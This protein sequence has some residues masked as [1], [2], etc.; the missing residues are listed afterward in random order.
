[1]T[2]DLLALDAVTLRDRLASGE[3]TALE[4]TDACLAR[5]AARD[6]VVKAWVWIDAEHARAQARQLDGLRAAGGPLG[7]LH[8]LPVGL[9]DVIDTAGIPTENGC[10]FDAGRVPDKDAFVVTRLK[11]E[12]AVIL[13]K[14]VTTELAYMQ[15]RQTTNPH[16]SAHTPG[17]SSSGSAAAVADGQVPLAIGT[18]T[19]GSVIRPASFCGV[20][21]FKPSFGALPRTG[22]LMQSHTLD[23][24]GVF[25]K[26][27]EGVAMVAEALFGHDVGD[28]ASRPRPTAHLLATAQ[29]EPPAPP[30]IAFAR[31]P[32]WEDADPELHAAFAGLCDTLGDHLTEIELPAAFDQAASARATVNFAEIAHHYRRY[33]EGGWEVVGDWTRQALTDGAAVTAADYLAALDVG[34]AMRAALPAIFARFDAILCPAALGTAPEGLEFTGDSIFNGL[35]TFAGTPAVTIPAFTAK[36]GLPM[37]AQLVGARGDDARLLRTADW[38]SRRIGLS[39]E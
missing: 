11:A 22:V 38:L 32:R 36:N 9:K 37:G 35:W 1:M 8:G 7:A 13:G 30:R 20:T 24:L 6:D 17:G 34:H 23:T 3:I 26:D 19:G 28:A 2:T 21:G 25:A 15:P 18:Q 5:I 4:L 12:G 14:T 33:A 27:I 10:P 16:H 29:T 31:P 39:A